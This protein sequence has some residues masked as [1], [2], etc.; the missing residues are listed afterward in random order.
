MSRSD[1]SIVVTGP[2]ALHY[3]SLPGFAETLAIAAGLPLGEFEA[4]DL[5]QQA[6]VSIVAGLDDPGVLIKLPRT[7]WHALEACF[8]TGLEPCQC[9]AV[10]AAA[11]LYF[12]R[13]AAS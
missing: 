1:A 5:A 11:R 13:R 10:L 9:E 6:F 2:P 7:L 12:N 8:E 3:D 4:L